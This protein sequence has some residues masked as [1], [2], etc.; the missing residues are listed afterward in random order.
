[1]T[2]SDRPVSSKEL[3]RIVETFRLAIEGRGQREKIDIHVFDL[4]ALLDA[5]SAHEPPVGQ[6]ETFFAPKTGER[7]VMGTG[8]DYKLTV[9]GPF[10][11]EAEKRD[12]CE[13]LAARLNRAAPPPPDVRDEL[14]REWLH[15]FGSTNDLSTRTRRALTKEV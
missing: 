11:S 10:H 2:S 5:A 4:K 6:W 1:M 3:S 12:Y 7:G 9:T 15:A 8:D 13:A 14:L